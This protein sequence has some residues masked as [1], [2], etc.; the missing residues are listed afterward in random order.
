M[1]IRQA[2]CWVDKY[3]ALRSIIR[4]KDNRILP[5]LTK[6]IKKISVY[7]SAERRRREKNQYLKVSGTEFISGFN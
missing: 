4:K 6:K 5:N 3:K 1:F 2:C 7:R